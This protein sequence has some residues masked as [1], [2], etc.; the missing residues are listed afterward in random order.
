MIYSF[1]PCH[2]ISIQL[3]FDFPAILILSLF[4]KCVMFLPG[5]GPW[6]VLFP[7]PTPNFLQYSWHSTRTSPVIMLI[8]LHYVCLVIQCFSLPSRVFHEGRDVHLLHHCIFHITVPE[9]AGIEYMN[10][11]SSQRNVQHV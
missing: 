6:H 7:A 9:I 4:F 8:T 2:F 1:P 11:Q 5:S 10:G 3:T